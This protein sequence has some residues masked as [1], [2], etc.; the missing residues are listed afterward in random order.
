M[1]PGLVLG[2]YVYFT[3]QAETTFKMEKISKCKSA[4][5]GFKYRLCSREK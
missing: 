3:L 5:R 2:Q 1:L 4:Y